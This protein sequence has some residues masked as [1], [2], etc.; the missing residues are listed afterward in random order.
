MAKERKK[1]PSSYDLAEELGLMA[2]TPSQFIRHA[3]HCARTK[4]TLGVIGRPGVG[5][6]ELIAQVSEQIS[7]QLIP[8]RLNGRDPT[9]M[10]LPYIYEDNHGSRRH[11]WSIPNW[12]LHKEDT[13][14]EGYNGR[15]IFFDELA[16]AYPAMQNR[17]G[18][19]MNERSLNNEPMHDNTWVVWAANFA[20]DKAAT[21][22]TPRQ[23]LNRSSVVVLVPSLEDTMAE[24]S[25]RQIRPELMAF[26]KLFPET[27]DS[28]DPDAM[29]NCT[30][31]SI[32]SLSPLMDKQPAADEELALYSSCIGKGFGAQLVGFLRTYRDLPK[33]SSI[34]SCPMKE[35]T[36]DEDKTDVMC[37]LAAMLGRAL[38]VQNAAPIIQ[39]LQRIPI[40]YCVF[41][42]REAAL[43]DSAL[44]NCAAMK[45]WVLKHGSVLI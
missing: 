27:L 19:V 45:N 6:T 18:E 31:R 20:Q 44:M 28:Y 30:P 11:A 2:L 33:L 41:A 37:A 1:H 21:Y 25:R 12:F 3:M 10:G 13:I 35:P 7:Y 4:K 9:D 24:A 23:I 22:P 38:T 34:V 42:L 43:R 29:V 17:V 40:E 8:E 26:M 39:Y 5:K 15:T 36:P 16:Q 32:F 14:P